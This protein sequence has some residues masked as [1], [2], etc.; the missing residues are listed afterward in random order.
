[1][2]SEIC[3]AHSAHGTI[4]YLECFVHMEIHNTLYE[5]YGEAESTAPWLMTYFNMVLKWI[6]EKLLPS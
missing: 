4:K 3:V 2:S 5:G 1:M 6:K